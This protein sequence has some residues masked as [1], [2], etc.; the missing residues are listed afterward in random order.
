MTTDV[1]YRIQNC[2]ARITLVGKKELGAMCLFASVFIFVL[3]LLFVL[4]ILLLLLLKC[5]F[6]ITKKERKGMEKSGWG[7]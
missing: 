6:Y 2:E 3:I 5:I 1:R 4:S 7:I